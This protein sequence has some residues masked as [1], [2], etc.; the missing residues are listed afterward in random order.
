MDER[1]MNQRVVDQICRAGRLNGK[2]YLAGECLALLDG[3]VVAV[4]NDLGGALR[5]LRAVD[6]DPARGMVFEVGP[7]VTD[8]IR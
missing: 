1:E 3:R 5:A 6:P 8:V 4:A 7:C 2:Q